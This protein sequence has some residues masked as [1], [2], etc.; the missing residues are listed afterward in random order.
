[1]SENVNYHPS[2]AQLNE[3]NQ[4]LLSTGMTVAVAAHLELCK[5]CRESSRRIEQDLAS[6]W[7]AD[8]TMEETDRFDH[9][10]RAAGEARIDAT[11]QRAAGPF[12][13]IAS[14]A[15]AGVQCKVAQS[16]GESGR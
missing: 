6:R 15:H 14:R 1:M 5:I 3:F 13:G 9:M 2:F 4:G 7:V 8:N 10:L 11:D 16:S 12:F